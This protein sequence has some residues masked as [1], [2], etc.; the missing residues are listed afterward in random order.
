V[1]A[2]AVKQHRAGVVQLS[3]KITELLTVGNESNAAKLKNK[4]SS[5]VVSLPSVEVSMYSFI[6]K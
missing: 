2:R 4:S 5:T 1:F 3:I 6:F